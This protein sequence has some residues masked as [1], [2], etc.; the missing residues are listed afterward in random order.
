MAA[1]F[2]LRINSRNRSVLLEATDFTGLTRRSIRHGW[3]AL[4]QDLKRVANTEILR[5]PK[6]GRVYFIRLPS[7]RIKRHIASAQGETHANLSGTLRRSLGWQVRGHTGMEFGYGVSSPV[8]AGYNAAPIYAEIEFGYG[9]VAPRPSLQN[10]I[11]ETNRNAERYFIE[12]FG[13]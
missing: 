7:G 12:R 2:E 3:F 4:A 10:A 1:D 13:E 9:R 6:S 8:G 11:N 5:K